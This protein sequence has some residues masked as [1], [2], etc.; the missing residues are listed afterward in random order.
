MERAP[1]TKEILEVV[2]RVKPVRVFVDSLSQFR[3]LARD[4]FQYRKQV[5]SFVHFLTDRRATVLA[6]PEGSPEAPDADLRFLADGVVCFS[7]SRG[8][9]SMEIV[10]FRGSSF[11]AG[12]HVFEL[13]SGGF[14]TSSS[15]SSRKAGGALFCFYLF[16]Y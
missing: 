3:Y 16:R 11:E 13:T 9:R 15:C 5:L 1:T 4:P 8:G 10:K 7:F 6:T 2:S 12:E 14:G